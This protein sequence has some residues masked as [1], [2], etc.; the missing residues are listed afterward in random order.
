MENLKRN[1][2]ILSEAYN[3]KSNSDEDCTLRKLVNRDDKIEEGRC[4]S[5]DEDRFN[6]DLSTEFAVE[7][8]QNLAAS[9]PGQCR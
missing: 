9:G 1:V 2:A 7:D 5:G 4:L 3:S 8:I 6:E